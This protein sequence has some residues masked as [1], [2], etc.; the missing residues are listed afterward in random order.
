MTESDDG[1]S[2]DWIPKSTSH[3]ESG[4]EV[5]F[6]SRVLCFCNSHHFIIL[7]NQTEKLRRRIYRKEEGD[8]VH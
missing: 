6:N 8:K 5:E 3:P 7:Y 2:S 4:L 1:Q